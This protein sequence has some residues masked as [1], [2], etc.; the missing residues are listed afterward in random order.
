[1]THCLEAKWRREAVLQKYGR[2]SVQIFAE[3]SLLDGRTVLFHGVELTDEDIRFLVEHRWSLTH[4]PVS[5][6]ADIAP[7]SRCLEMGVEV[8]LGTDFGSAD[9][10]EVMRVAHYLRKG[11]PVELDAETVFHMATIGGARAYGIEDRIGKIAK[12]HAADLV[13]ID[14]S[15]AGLLPIV[16]LDSFTNR[17]HNLLMECR[18]HMVRGVMVAGEW[19]VEDGSLATVDQEELDAE[20]AAIARRV[21]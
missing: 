3:R 4:C 9:I 14:G 19:I 20:Y 8:A 16:E 1:M 10:W 7:V 11:R 6:L 13:L 2:S 21:G 15:D 5:N 12:G 18:P 17:L